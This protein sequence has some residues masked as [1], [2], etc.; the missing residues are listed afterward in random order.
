MTVKMEGVRK[1]VPRVRVWLAV[2]MVG[3]VPRRM[4]LL[5]TN[6]FFFRH[7]KL[8]VSMRHQGEV[9]KCIDHQ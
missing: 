5:G 6:G 9:I 3:N 1:T 2:F 8:K 7:M 4:V